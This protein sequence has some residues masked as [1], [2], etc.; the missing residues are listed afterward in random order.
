MLKKF[1]K[2]K[3]VKVNNAS[4]DVK[5]HIKALDRFNEAVADLDRITEKMFNDSNERMKRLQKI[6]F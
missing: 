6:P 2:G 1:F 3:E 4:K 5:E